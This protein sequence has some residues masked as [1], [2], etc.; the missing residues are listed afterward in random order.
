MKKYEETQENLFK[1][2]KN[3][4]SGLKDVP[5]I[6]KYL[7]SYSHYDVIG[8]KTFNILLE[9]GSMNL[10]EI[11]SKGNPPVL[12]TDVAE[13]WQTILKVACAIESIHHLAHQENQYFG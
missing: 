13:F 8:N 9:F 6:V 3:S 2:E 7:G 5:G 4:Y 10:W 11:L 1:R 12:F